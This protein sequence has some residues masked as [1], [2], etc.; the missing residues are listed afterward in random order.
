VRSATLATTSVQMY[1]D[2]RCGETARDIT[3][4]SDRSARRS[5]SPLLIMELLLCIKSSPLSLSVS[6]FFLLDDHIILASQTDLGP[7]MRFLSFLFSLLAFSALQV[8]ARMNQLASGTSHDHPTIARRQHHPRGT[9]LADI[10]APIDISLLEKI[11][12]AG[13]LKTSASLE[14]HICICIS[15]VPIFVKTDVRAK[16]YV[17][18]VGEQSAIIN[19]KDMVRLLNSVVGSKRLTVYRSERLTRDKLATSLPTLLLCF[20]WEPAAIPVNT[21]VTRLIANG[22]ASASAIHPCSSATESALWY[23]T[24]LSYYEGLVSRLCRFVVRPCRSIPWRPPVGVTDSERL[25]VV[26]LLS[27]R[28]TCS[29]ITRPH[30]KRLT[31]LLEHITT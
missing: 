31:M 13:I 29:N 17:D 9:S 19:I 16:G 28:S 22:T 23:A 14:V 26:R 1:H 21:G 3:R 6:I 25:Y 24:H 18:H 20:P 8:F 7:T 4:P 11:S 5:R 15:V 10:C 12:A 27:C 2:G 30:L